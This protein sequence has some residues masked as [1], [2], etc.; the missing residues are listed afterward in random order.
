MDKEEI[1]AQSIFP[2]M[3]YFTSLNINTDKEKILLETEKGSSVSNK[4]GW[5]SEKYTQSTL[6]KSLEKIINKTHSVVS[7]VY[8]NLGIQ[9]NQSCLI[10]G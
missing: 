2:T 9:K 10:V 8:K 3:L 4:K 5:Q 7:L 6:P 1:V